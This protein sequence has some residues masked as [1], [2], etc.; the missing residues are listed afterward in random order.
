MT[1]MYL[2]FLALCEI[3]SFHDDEDAVPGF[4]GCDAA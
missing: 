1:V 2:K 4:L 3:W